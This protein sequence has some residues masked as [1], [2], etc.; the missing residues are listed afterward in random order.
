MNHF[1]LKSSDII[2]FILKIIVPTIVF[3]L[4]SGFTVV[5]FAIVDYLVNKKN[6]IRYGLA[7]LFRVIFYCVLVSLFGIYY[8]DLNLHYKNKFEANAIVFI[9]CTFWMIYS[10]RIL[11]S[12]DKVKSFFNELEYEYDLKEFIHYHIQLIN[13][14]FPFTFI[15]FLFLIILPNTRY[16]LPEFTEKIALKYYSYDGDSIDQIPNLKPELLKYCEAMKNGDVESLIKFLPEH[17]FN[18]QIEIE[19]FIS[20]NKKFNKDFTFSGNQYTNIDFSEPQNF[21][22]SSNSYE[23]LIYLKSELYTIQNK[24]LRQDPV[25]CISENNGKNWKITN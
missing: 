8:Y 21:H 16:Y 3:I 15:V 2:I 25:Y 12:I 5:I 20:V 17:F 23:V 13:V 1:L 19:T 9:A 7:H 18:N 4:F 10:F 24:I 22:K 6:G 14:V 11:F